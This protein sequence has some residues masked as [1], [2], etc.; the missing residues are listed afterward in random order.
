M[1]L[2]VSALLLLAQGAPL[3]PGVGVARAQTDSSQQAAAD[4]TQQR[5]QGDQAAAEAAQQAVGNELQQT[6]NLE[7]QTIN[8]E[9]PPDFQQMEP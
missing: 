3:G 5:A 4:S 8:E 2:G 7:F 6:E 1:A 9:R